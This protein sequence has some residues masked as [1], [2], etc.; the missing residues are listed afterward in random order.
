[1]HVLNVDFARASLL[2]QKRSK[3][4]LVRQKLEVAA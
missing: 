1:M 4:Q 3:L 2:D